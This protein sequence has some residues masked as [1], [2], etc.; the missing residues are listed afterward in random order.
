MSMA[1]RPIDRRELAIIISNTTTKSA[2]TNITTTTTISLV[3]AIM[4]RRARHL[5][6]LE[7][8]NQPTSFKRHG[9]VSFETWV[10]VD[11]LDCLAAS[12]LL[13]AISL[14]LTLKPIDTV[15]LPSYLIHD[16]SIRVVSSPFTIASTSRT[17]HDV[18]ARSSIPWEPPAFA[19]RRALPFA[20][21]RAIPAEELHSHSHHTTSSASCL[22]T[23][24]WKYRVEWDFIAYFEVSIVRRPDAEL[25]PTFHP[26]DRKSTRLNSSHANISYGSFPL[27]S[28]QVGWRRGSFGYHGDDGHFFCE[29]R[30]D[31]IRATAL[32]SLKAGC[33]A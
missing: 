28:S 19:M 31:R 25:P 9:A 27:A 15:L 3:L 12:S 6:L 29:V 8:T 7:C 20:F 11:A 32:A 23:P 26:L 4:A 1:P 14:T 33:D 17:S 24:S 10:R 13:N 2:A 22:E 16:A 21:L 5:R 30:F 18:A